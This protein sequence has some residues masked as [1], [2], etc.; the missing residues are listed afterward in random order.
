MKIVISMMSCVILLLI[1]GFCVFGFAATFEP[2]DHPTMFLLFRLGYG[3]V[4]LG[5]TVTI[6]LLL[7]TSLSSLGG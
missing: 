4:G 7:K 1:L 2:S 5:C 6:G 3:I